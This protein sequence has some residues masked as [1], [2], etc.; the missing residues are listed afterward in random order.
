MSGSGKRLIACEMFVLI[1]MGVPEYI[2][3]KRRRKES[4]INST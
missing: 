3:T 1:G 2:Y 4:D